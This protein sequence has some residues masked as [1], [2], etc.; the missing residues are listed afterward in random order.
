MISKISAKI[1]IGGKSLKY[2]AS[3]FFHEGYNKRNRNK[4]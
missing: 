4:M 1:A 2:K 3:C